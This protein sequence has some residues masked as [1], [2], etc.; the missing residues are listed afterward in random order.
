MS[1]DLIIAA[2]CAPREGHLRDIKKAGLQAVELYLS[3]EIMENLPK[4]IG[5]CK[6]FPFRYAVHAPNAVYNPRKLR[7]LTEAINAEIAVFHNV[8]WEDEWK[9]VAKAFKGV[10]TKLCV[11]NTSST[12]DSVKFMR[13]YGW[14]RALDL[15]HAQMGSAGV[16]EEEFIT[17]MKEA[18]HIHL[19]GYTHGSQL[20]HTH[21]HHS[22][23]HN[24][25]LLDLLR[26]ARYSGFVV[27]EAKKSLQTYA[28]FKKLKEFYQK[29]RNK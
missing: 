5:L 11:E 13:R 14:G 29:W 12:H 6:K 24:S 3:E 23:R 25:Y 27:S 26:K 20:W 28:E 1:R 15:E 10:K 8:Y 21:I 4:V 18:A 7:K 19:T 16:Y 17:V 9:R 2:K 22:P